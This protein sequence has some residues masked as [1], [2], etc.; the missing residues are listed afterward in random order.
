MILSYAHRF[1]FFRIP[2][3]ASTSCQSALKHQCKP[4]DLVTWI[5]EDPD[6]SGFSSQE[7]LN[8]HA[9]PDQV[10]DIGLLSKE[11]WNKYTK[12]IVARNI[13]ERII[14]SFWYV[15]QY[16]RKEEYQNFGKVKSAFV[17][18]IKGLYLYGDPIHHAYANSLGFVFNGKYWH[19]RLSDG[20]GVSHFDMDGTLA[21]DIALRY[22][23]L[24]EDYDNLCKQLKISSIKLP[25]FKTQH[26]KLLLPVDLYYN[27]ELVDLIW[28]YHKLEIEYFDWKLK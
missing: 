8:I 21:Y 9:T 14:S 24:Q 15:S 18:Y 26:K 13:W 22:E 16:K 25:R 6:N 11:D 17:K 12:I 7:G 23:N 3:S 27:N 2:K 28:K 5:E 1:I 19:E 10:K 20:R 4:G